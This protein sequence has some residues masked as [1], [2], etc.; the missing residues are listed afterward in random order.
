[1]QR[2][3]G[4]NSGGK[5]A[6]AAVFDW[7]TVTPM[8]MTAGPSSI[9]TTT[10]SGTAWTSLDST[11]WMNPDSEALKRRLDKIEERLAILQPALELHEK[12]PAL[13]RAYEDYKILEKLINGGHDPS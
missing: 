13:R 1:M 7:T 3:Q 10:G 9:L 11:G 8:T 4:G 6:T 5:V 12:F 2:S